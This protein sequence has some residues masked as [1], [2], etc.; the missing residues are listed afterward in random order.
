MPT[1]LKFSFQGRPRY[2]N[3]ALIFLPSE[4]GGVRAF[5]F[6]CAGQGKLLMFQTIPKLRD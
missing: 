2:A 6:L 3:I 5:R 1:L 4:V